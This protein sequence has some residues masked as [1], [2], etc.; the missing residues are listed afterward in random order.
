[1][2]CIFSLI[3]KT[4][5]N[6]GYTEIFNGSGQHLNFLRFSLLNLDRNFSKYS[7]YS[8]NEEIAL[9]VIRGT[10][11]VTV[12]SIFFYNIGRRNSAFES[13][14]YTV[15]VPTDSHYNIELSKNCVD[16]EVA[17]CRSVAERH[18]EPFMINPE[19]VETVPRGKGQWKRDVR[20]ILVDNVNGMV[21]RIIM[22][23][24]INSA[25]EWSGYPPHKHEEN[26]PPNELPFE[27]IYYYLLD[28]PNGFGIQV[29]YG[30]KFEEDRGYVVK[31]GNAFA[32]PDGYHPVVAAGGYRLYYLWFMAGPAGRKLMP[33]LDPS[34]AWVEK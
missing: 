22:G 19:K 21:D 11:D 20:N 12:D 1:M 30:S 6:S 31:S 33:H 34:H 32:I 5:H 26:S 14:P 10:V 28:P 27:E 18:F 17:I 29:H 4:T 3:G 7:G 15:Y 2:I 23:E 24:T 16:A 8:G 13:P 9:V 25:G